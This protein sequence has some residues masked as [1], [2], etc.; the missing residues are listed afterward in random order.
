MIFFITSLLVSVIAA[1]TP[2]MLAATGE[3][4]AEKAG[5][6]NLGVEG[7]M[8][9]GAVT[10]FVVTHQTGST[11]LGI[12]AAILAGAAMAL[13]FSVLTLTVLANQIATGLALT[14]FG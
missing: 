10:G 5:V 13:I 3:L 1:S 9:V 7:M 8:L 6:L 2:L 14:L 4:I 11:T 12:L